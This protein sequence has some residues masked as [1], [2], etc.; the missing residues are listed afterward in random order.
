MTTQT[1][2]TTRAEKA[3]VDEAEDIG[4]EPEDGKGI[5]ARV[6]TSP[7][8]GGGLKGLWGRANERAAAADAQKGEKKEKSGRGKA[9]A[10]AALLH[11]LVLVVDWIMAFVTATGVIPTLAAYLHRESGASRGQLTVDGTIA[12]WAA[13]L[14][15]LVLVLAA[16][17][18]VL[19]RGMWR[20]AAR[21]VQRITA[22][23]AQ[24]GAEAQPAVPA[25]RAGSPARKKTTNRKRS[26]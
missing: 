2:E 21:R 9:I 4:W 26:N 25:K 10:F 13:P 3:D 8:A 20:W 19:M 15:F 6:P 7:R 17:E 22:A 24:P 14:L 16:G 1:P 12:L 5:E 23:V 11:G 18:L